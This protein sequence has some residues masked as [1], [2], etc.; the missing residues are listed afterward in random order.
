[1]SHH[2]RCGPGPYQG[3]PAFENLR[4]NFA[5]QRNACTE[6]EGEGWILNEPHIRC[7]KCRVVSVSDA[8]V[9]AAV[10]EIEERGL[11]AHFTVHDRNGFPR[12]WQVQQRNYYAHQDDQVMGEAETLPEALWAYKKATKL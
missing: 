8:E 4:K 7:S 1:M 10:R 12:L 6:C 9:A 5:A 3:D 2:I 11:D